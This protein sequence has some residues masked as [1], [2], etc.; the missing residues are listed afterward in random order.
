M[1]RVTVVCAEC[2]RAVT[3]DWPA[4]QY[5]STLYDE[6]TLDGGAKLPK[7]WWTQPASLGGDNRL[8]CPEHSEAPAV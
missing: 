1:I 2:G 6:V 7:G 5:S 8:R 4:E 3:V